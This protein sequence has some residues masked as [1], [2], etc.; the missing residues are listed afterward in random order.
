V[1]IKSSSVSVVR[2]SVTVTVGIVN[3]CHRCHGSHTR[4]HKIVSLQEIVVEPVSILVGFCGCKCSG[5]RGLNSWVRAKTCLRLI[6]REVFLY[7]TFEV[8]RGV[9]A[10]VACVGVFFTGVGVVLED[11]ACAD[12]VSAIGAVRYLHEGLGGRGFVLVDI[13]GEHGAWLRG[14][15]IQVL[16]RSKKGL[17]SFFV[18]NSGNKPR[19]GASESTS[20]G[21]PVLLSDNSVVDGEG[22]TNNLTDLDHELLELVGLR[23]PLVVGERKLLVVVGIDSDLVVV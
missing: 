16:E 15:K 6:S 13:Y 23:I 2:V 1:T 7:V 4:V 11:C 21:R 8:G 9:V 18:S 3:G 22:A 20:L 17:H 19:S 5:A 14:G 12:K 10:S